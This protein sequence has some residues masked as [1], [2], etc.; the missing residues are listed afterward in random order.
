[1]D[2]L[3]LDIAGF[4]NEWSDLDRIFI[5]VLKCW[6]WALT[7]ITKISIKNVSRFN[8]ILFKIKVLLHNVVYKIF[9][10]VH[11]NFQFHNFQ[12]NNF[13]VY[14]QVNFFM[15]F[16]EFIYNFFTVFSEFIQNLFTIFSEFIQNFSELFQDFFRIHFEFKLI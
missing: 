9:I 12:F 8:Q 5:N 13:L 14:F 16:S 2:N 10:N 11:F 4:E 7:F 15:I 1:M 3:S 6:N